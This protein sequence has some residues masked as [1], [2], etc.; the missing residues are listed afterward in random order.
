MEIEKLKDAYK[1]NAAA[2]AI[3]DELES[4]R[5][6]QNVTMLDRMIQLLSARGLDLK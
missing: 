3:C 6:N 4:R 5:K 2:K 1:N